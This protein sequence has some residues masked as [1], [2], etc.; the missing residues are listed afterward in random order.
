MTAVGEPGQKIKIKNKKEEALYFP[1]FARRY[2][3]LAQIFG[4]VFVSWT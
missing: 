2:S 4:Y 1:L 3:R